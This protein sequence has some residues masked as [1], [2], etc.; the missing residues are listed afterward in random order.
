MNAQERREEILETLKC[1]GS[2]LTASALASTYDVSRQIIVGDI[3]ILRASGHP[4][5]ATSRGY[6]MDPQREEFPYI[7]TIV[8]KHDQKG[9]EAELNAV[10]DNGGTVIDV[11][12][13][14]AVYGE[15]TGKLDIASRYDVS[16]FVERMSGEDRPLS[17]LSGGIHMHRIGCKDEVTFR[18]IKDDIGKL[19]MLVEE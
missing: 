7:G 12:I 6:V 18:R 4:I 2:P 9:M 17:T 1:A 15:L 5:E 10:V 19:G 11:I 16:V 3:S 13:D 14:H 8:C